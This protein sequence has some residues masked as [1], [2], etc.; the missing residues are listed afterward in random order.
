[1]FRIYSIYLMEIYLQRSHVFQ[2]IQSRLKIVYVVTLVYGGR[3]DVHRLL[4]HIY[5]LLWHRNSWLGIHWWLHKRHLVRWHILSLIKGLL[6]HLGI[7]HR[8]WYL[9]RHSV[10]TTRIIVWWCIDIYVRNIKRHWHGYVNRDFHDFNRRCN[11]FS[12]AIAQ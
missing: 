7:L 11:S 9:R 4:R 6:V 1:M 10:V 12:G 3:R 8:W 2:S 5:W